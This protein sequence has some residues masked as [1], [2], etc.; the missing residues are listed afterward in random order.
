MSEIEK[1]E[2]EKKLTRRRFLGL[3]TG[4]WQVP[5]G[6]LNSIRHPDPGLFKLKGEYQLIPR[7]HL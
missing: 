2:Q 4:L 7:V 3:L 6:Y 1:I 5:A